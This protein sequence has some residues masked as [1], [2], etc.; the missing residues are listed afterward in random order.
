MAFTGASLADGQVATTWGTIYAPGLSAKA[1]LRSADFYNTNAVTQTLEFAI[2]RAGQ[3]R[4][5]IA[6]VTLL[7]NE[8]CELLTDNEVIT[9]SPS[10]LLEAQTTTTTAVDYT[11]TGATEL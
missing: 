11:I 4:R 2:T 1:I 8:K 6:R 9:L 10:D 5:I 3:P 7:Q